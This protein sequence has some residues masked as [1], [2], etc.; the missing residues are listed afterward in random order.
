MLIVGRPIK[1]WLDDLTGKKTYRR[2]REREDR[3]RRLRAQM[4][5]I[6]AILST[7]VYLF[8][9]LGTLNMH[10][11]WLSVPFY[12][13]EI[14]GLFILLSF[15]LTTGYPRYHRRQ[16][17]PVEHPP[18]VDV[19]VT[20]CGEP[21]KI[22]SATLRATARIDY[23]RKRVYVLDDNGDP[24]V[25]ELAA[26]LGF[27]YFAREVHSDAKAGNLNYALQR[28]NG[29]VVLTLDADQVPHKDIIKKT[30][31][32]FSHPNIGFVQTKQVFRVPEGDS[33][34]NSDPIFYDLMQLGK[35]T[36][37]AAFSCGSG[38]MYR[39]KALEEIGGFSTWNIVEDLH[40]SMLLHDKGWRSVY[41]NY[42]LSMG[43]APGD[44]WGVYKQRQQWAADS[45]RILFWDNPFRRRGLSLKQR[46]Q[47]AHLG[48][49]YL[50]AGI[51]MPIFYVVPIISLFT[52]R[53]VI[54]TESWHYL[55]YRLPSLVLTMYA[56]NY[57]YKIAK[58]PIPFNQAVATWLGYFPCYIYAT[59]IALTSR[60]SKPVYKVNNKTWDPASK[61]IQFI[62]IL[63]QFLIILLS[64][65]GILY[66]VSVPRIGN[67][68][69]LL[70]NTLWVSWTAWIL[71]RVCI[72]P[73]KIGLAQKS[74]QPTPGKRSVSDALLLQK[75]RDHR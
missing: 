19:F 29:E 53:F 4:L 32:Y 65:M 57:A 55:L 33:F 43:T 66:C 58:S 36:D 60:K 31:G 70:N 35:D 6:L 38:V 51:A 27:E 25:R 73:F 62:G 21:Y 15:A 5:F 45:L 40:T 18:T 49:V 14:A 1:N 68:N 52:G 12:L 37:N 26:K 63:P 69:A 48:F 61:T 9:L 22:I 74:A 28:T 67:L 30:V 42:S 11:W 20:V 3:K 75:G 23:P 46:F 17:I 2:Y 59:L 8:W 16:G 64:I 34:C 54:N 71:H 72:A 7:L 47:Y 10:L 44:I 24:K 39:R 56:Y 50:F 13:C 41:H